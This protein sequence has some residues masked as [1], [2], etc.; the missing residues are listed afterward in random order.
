MQAQPFPNCCGIV[1]FCG[2]G[3]TYG[4]HAGAAYGYAPPDDEI[5]AWLERNETHQRIVKSTCLV[6]LNDEQRGK[7]G[8][9][10]EA[11]GYKKSEP[12]WHPVHGTYETV[13]FKALYDAEEKMKERPMW[14]PDVIGGY[15]SKTTRLVFRD[16]A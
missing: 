16:A 8:H 2:F 7:I 4:A 1:I 3:H 10:F 9:I 14:T 11:R 15:G 6:A 5:I 13:Y 12:M